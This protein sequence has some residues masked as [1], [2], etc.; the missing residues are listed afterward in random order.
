MATKKTDS[1]SVETDAAL[2]S[3]GVQTDDGVG[4]ESGP[5]PRVLWSPQMEALAR[6]AMNAPK[7]APIIESMEELA[8]RIEMDIPDIL[9]RKYRHHVFRW[10]SLNAPTGLT[11]YGGYY[12]PVTRTSHPDLPRELFDDGTGC[13]LYK[14]QAFLTFTRRENVEL[15][16]K[17]TER[18]FSLKS[19]SVLNPNERKYGRKDQVVIEPTT[20][21][22]GYD[23]G[24]L[25]DSPPDYEA[26]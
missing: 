13:I 1:T 7:D 2:E 11:S 6:L 10:D 20:Q 21:E 8:P 14:G 18:A 25:D 15:R 24:V 9:K 3:V 16:Q 5:T 17:A 22:G 23:V 4:V 26:A 12:V 19:E